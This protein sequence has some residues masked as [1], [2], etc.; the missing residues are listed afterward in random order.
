MHV[1]QSFGESLEPNQMIK[2]PFPMSACRL[3]YHLQQLATAN[4]TTKFLALWVVALPFILLF[5][6]M[7]RIAAR[8]TVSAAMY[9]VN[10][11]A[12]HTDSIT[13]RHGPA[14]FHRADD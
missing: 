1:Q 7:Y 3:A 8:T 10:T 2:N 12:L 5:G 6:S 9:K 14:G 11:Q 13:N 4:L